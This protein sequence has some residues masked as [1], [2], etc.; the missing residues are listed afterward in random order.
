MI[1]RHKVNAFYTAPTA[2][3]ALMKYGDAPVASYDLSSLRVLGSVGEPINPAAWEWY[4]NIVGRKKCTIVDTYWQTETGGIIMTPLP[5]I[6]TLKPGSCVGPFFGIEPVILDELTGQ[7]LEGNN[8]KGVLALK[9]TWPSTTRTVYG[10]HQR[11][12]TVY[13]KPY[14]GF[15]F[16]GDGCYRDEEGYYFIIGRVDDVLNVS[17]H[18]LGTAELE[19]AF[20]QHEACAEAAVVA[21]SH[22]I[23]GQA[24]YAFCILKEGYKASPEM[25]A[26]LKIQ[27]RTTIGPFA[28]P[29]AVVITPGLPKTRSGKIM[30][31]ILRK[32]A[33]REFTNIGDTTTLSDP[34]I[35]EQ[36]IEL[37]SARK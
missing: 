11:Y 13:M 22:P 14:P 35:V 8:V 20:V 21:I 32:I 16:T 7:I 27:I 4:Y 28:T 18:R 6:H 26:A 3:R 17:G 34:Q 10:D 15:Y 23:K 1:Q 30:R 36:L 12:L 19:S 2:I 9:N 29:E 24:I 5:G 31:R 25:E 33:E 37:V